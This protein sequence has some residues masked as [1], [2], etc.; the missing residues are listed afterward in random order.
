MIPSKT[1]WSDTDIVFSNVTESRYIFFKNC[2]TFV[3]Y[4]KVEHFVVTWL[5]FFHKFTPA[6]TGV[7]NNQEVF[8]ADNEQHD[9]INSFSQIVFLLPCYVWVSLLKIC[10]KH[11]K[12]LVKMN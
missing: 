10:Q 7:H 8:S 11:D 1:R 12:I 5:L 6:A 2:T 4:I 3:C 9:K